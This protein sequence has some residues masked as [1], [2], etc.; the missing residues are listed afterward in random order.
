MRRYLG[1]CSLNIRLG[2]KVKITMNVSVKKKHGLRSFA[3]SRIIDSLFRFE[4]YK[5]HAFYVV[6]LHRLL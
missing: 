6:S 3:V 2:I 1:N 4:I 5:I